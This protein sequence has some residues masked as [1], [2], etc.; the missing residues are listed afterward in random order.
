V[1]SLFSLLLLFGSTL[2]QGSKKNANSGA[3]NMM[4]GR[5]YKLGYLTMFIVLKREKRGG[6]K[7]EKREKRKELR[8]F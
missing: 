5:C 2:P 4:P 3:E 8:I 1:V 6:K 7:E